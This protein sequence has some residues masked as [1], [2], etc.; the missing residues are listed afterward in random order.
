MKS[1]LLMCTIVLGILLSNPCFMYGRNDFFPE[2]L[3]AVQTDWAHLGEIKF[4]FLYQASYWTWGTAELYVKVISGNTFYQVR[5]H[6][7]EYL[8][9]RGNYVANGQHFN[10]KFCDG[11]YYFNLP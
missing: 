7:K 5:L 8:V 10:A 4:Y 11:N 1:K 9:Y 2:T 6:N 3:A